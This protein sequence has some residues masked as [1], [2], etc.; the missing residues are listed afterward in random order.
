MIVG[1]MPRLRPDLRKSP[2]A[3]ALAL[4][5]LTEAE[6]AG[7]IGG[8]AVAASEPPRQEPTTQPTTQPDRPDQPG[9]IELDPV[10]KY[11]D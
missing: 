1:A 2:N 9:P 3:R 10:P 5:K 8:A 7:V 11:S 6:L 4:R